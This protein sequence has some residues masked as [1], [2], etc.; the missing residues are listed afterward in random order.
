M[1]FEFVA[2]NLALDFA[3]TVH[4]H[5]MAD[6][7]D[8]LKSA[9]DLVAWSAQAGL[10]RN[11][12]SH[13]VGGARADQLRFRRALALRA[14][15]YDDLPFGGRRKET[16]G[17]GASGI[18]ELL[19]ECDSG[20][21]ISPNGQSLSAGVAGRDPSFGSRLERDSSFGRGPPDIGRLDARSAVLRKNLFLVV[22]RYQSQ[23]AAT[24][25][26]YE[27]LRQPRQSPTLS[28]PPSPL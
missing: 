22:R 27:S 2:G 28:P 26:R 25:V 3:N 5:G 21:R 13:R 9:P 20:R 24:L 15:L 1:D 8:D 12:E 6:P 11:A 10:L 23:R 17:R 18:S 4:C 7:G 14:V 16:P 19:P